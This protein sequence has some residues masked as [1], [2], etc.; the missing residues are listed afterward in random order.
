MWRGEVLPNPNG[1]GF[2]AMIETTVCDMSEDAAHLVLRDALGKLSDAVSQGPS[3]ARDGEARRG[4]VK[5]YNTEKGFGFIVPDD[6]G[7]DVFVH[8]SVVKATGRDYLAPDTEVSYIAVT[9]PKGPQ[10]QTLVSA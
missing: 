6:G 10:V 3:P 8:A 5:W 4:T 2:Y 1:R 7:Q 9:G